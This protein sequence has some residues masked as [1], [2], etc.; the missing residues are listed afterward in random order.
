MVFETSGSTGPSRRWVRT[1]A[2]MRAEVEV[3]SGRTTGEVDLV[4]N[5]SPPRHLFGALFGEWLPRLRGV[6]AVQAWERPFEFPDVPAG[7]RLLVV[8]VPIAWDLLRRNRRTL[9][10]ARS[11]VALHSSAA[12]PPA[13]RQ[14]VADTGMVAHEILGSTETGGIAHRPLDPS[15]PWQVLPDV[16]VAHDRGDDAGPHRLV[17]RGPRLAR[18]EQ[19]PAP[20]ASWATG[21]LVEF[22]GPGRFRLLGRESDLV[23]VNGV[24]V[25]LAQ[26]ERQ[27]GARLPGARC[28]PVPAPRDP[29]AGEGYAVFWA[30]RGPRLGAADIRRALHGLPSPVRVV[31]LPSIPTTPSG[32][33]D[34]QALGRALAARPAAPAGTRGGDQHR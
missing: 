25:H 32:K 21:D 6:P 8:C 30:S 11:V 34:R 18:R 3:V 14:L 22:T 31:E 10:R 7:A 26:V 15:A 9:E 16:T 1:G 5:Y 27:L 33:P 2:Q 23:K 12:P 19:D 24:K 28:V 4:I 29:L 13:A 20:P 17:V